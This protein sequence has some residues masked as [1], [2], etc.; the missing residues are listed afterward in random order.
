MSGLVDEGVMMARLPALRIGAIALP[1]PDICGPRAAIM[2][3][4]DT[5]L[6]A[7][8]AACAGSYWPAVALPSSYFS[9]SKVMPGTS[10]DLSASSKAMT[11]PLAIRPAVVASAPVKD[12]LMPT[13]TTVSAARAG[14]TPAAEAATNAAAALNVERRVSMRSNSP[15]FFVTVAASWPP[16]P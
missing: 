15:V 4:S 2:A 14:P 11:A 13:F 9:R 8:V 12:R 16:M 1:A 6:R 3:W 10:W 7:L 5:I